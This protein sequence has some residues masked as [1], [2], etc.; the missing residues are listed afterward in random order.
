MLF[1]PSGELLNHANDENYLKKENVHQLGVKLGTLGNLTHSVLEFGKEVSNC[2]NAN[3]CYIVIVTM[4]VVIIIT[5]TLVKVQ[6][7]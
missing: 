6:C 2:H 7:I 1:T 4:I 3:E 5:T